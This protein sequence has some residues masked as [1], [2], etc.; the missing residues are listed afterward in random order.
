L[1]DNPVI[2]LNIAFV[3]PEAVPYAK[4]GGLADISGILP[5]L[6]AA[7][8]HSVRLFLPKYRQIS[9]TFPNSNKLKSDFKLDIE[10]KSFTGEIWSLS[11]KSSNLEIIL[12]GNDFLFNRAELYRDNSTGEDYADNDDR[13]IFFSRAVLSAM[14]ILGWRPD[15][16]HANDWQTALIPSYLKTLY[17]DDDFYRNTSA[18]FTIHNMA[19]QGQFPA[20]VFGKIGI[21]KAYFTPT[22]PFEFWGKVNFLKSAISFADRITTVSPTYAEEIQETSDFGMGLEG[23][24]KEKKDRLVGILNGVDYEDWNPQKDKLI[25]YNYILANL[26]GKR[27]NKLAL[28]HQADLPLRMEEPLIGMISRLD[29]QKG[30]DLI[31]EAMDQIM[32]MN[33][34]FILLGTGVEKYH[35]FFKDM[36]KKYPDKFRVYLKFDNSLAHLI[37]AGADMFL[38]PS[39]YEPCG[40]NQMYSLKYGAVPIVRKTGGL[41]DTVIDFNEKDKTGTGFVFDEYDSES[42]LKAIKRAVAVYNRRRTWYKVVKQGMRQDFSWE[43]SAGKYQ[44]LYLGLHKP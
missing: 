41:A 7:M 38:M 40:L 24:L 27:K 3:T 1:W 29:N 37:E 16:V 15:I 17:Q 8:G 21:D 33:L 26:S 20:E 23:V 42:M 12:I 28:L 44:D 22:G 32:A 39:R 13:F 18:V 34:Q 4:T 14:K 36:E 5:R 35:L 19:Y 25:P 11:N 2:P 30:F 6:L 9:I 31:E 43:K 10:D